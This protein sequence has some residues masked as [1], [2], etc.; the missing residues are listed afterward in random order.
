VGDAEK[1]AKFVMNRFFDHLSTSP[2]KAGR[3]I[4]PVGRGGGRRQQATPL[5]PNQRVLVR[6]FG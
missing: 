2:R 3:V 5:Q 1:A 6:G 4:E